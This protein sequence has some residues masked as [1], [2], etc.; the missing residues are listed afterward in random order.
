[1]LTTS[2]PVTPEQTTRQYQCLQ[3][4]LFEGAT[5]NAG[6]LSLTWQRWSR[7]A[8]LKGP[9]SVAVLLGIIFQAGVSTEQSGDLVE[10]CLSWDYYA[11]VQS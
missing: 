3:A 10:K 2:A 6:N 5:A 4:T 7:H 8:R 11:L 1:M 9:I